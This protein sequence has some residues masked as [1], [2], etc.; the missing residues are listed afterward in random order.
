MCQDT[1]QFYSRLAIPN[2]YTNR[3]Y[4]NIRLYILV[5]IY[6]LFC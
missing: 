1:C 6:G 2:S 3:T 4:Y 5:T